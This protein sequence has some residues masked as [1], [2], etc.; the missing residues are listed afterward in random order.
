MKTTNINQSF[1][2]IP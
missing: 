1:N 2:I